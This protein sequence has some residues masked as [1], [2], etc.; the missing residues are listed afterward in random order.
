MKTSKHLNETNI[1]LISIPV[2][3]FIY[4]RFCTPE[5]FDYYFSSGFINTESLSYFRIF[6]HYVSMFLI[7]AVI[8]A[9]IIHFVFKKKLSEYGLAS[10]DSK[11][12]YSI[13]FGSLIPLVL[14]LSLTILTD[15]EKFPTFHSCYP[16]IPGIGGHTG[17][18]LLNTAFLFLFYVA[19]E[20]F[21]RGYI[22]FGLKNK[23]GTV[24]AILIQTI[25]SVLVHFSKPDAEL[26][27]SIPGEILL[28]LLAVRTGSVWYGIL[29]HF[30]MGVTIELA[31]ILF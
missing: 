27:F 1:I 11:F 26:F 18:F 14:L 9:F 24:P 25:P 22:L 3:L 16:A 29:I 2:L 19:F 23:L 21:Y 15:G 7:L 5:Y 28:G 6:Y 12:G 31:G 10:G 8:P 13:V 20:F 30:F 17:F 4:L